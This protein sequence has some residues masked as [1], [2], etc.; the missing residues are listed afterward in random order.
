MGMAYT[1]RDY[2]D[3]IFLI[4]IIKAKPDMYGDQFCS[5]FCKEANNWDQTVQLA[6]HLTRVA[7][8]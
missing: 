1:L 2:I 5:G 4:T 3:E 7:L 6:E 8:P